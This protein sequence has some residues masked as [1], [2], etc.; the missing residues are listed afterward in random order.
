V[1]VV[2]GREQ[3]GSAGGPELAKFGETGP[4]PLIQEIEVQPDPP[5][6]PRESGTEVAELKDFRQPVAVESEAPE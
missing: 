1:L 4:A 2:A 6:P 5:I 3:G